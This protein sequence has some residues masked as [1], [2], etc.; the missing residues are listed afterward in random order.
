MGLFDFFKREEEVVKA[1]RLTVDDEPVVEPDTEFEDVEP[2]AKEAPEDR[3]TAGPFDASEDAP[4]VPYVDLG[5]LRIPASA[6]LG[7][8]LEMDDATKRLVAVALDLNG[9]TLQ[10]QAFAAP[11]SSGLWNDVR[12]KLVETLKTQGGVANE[13]ET[14]IGTALHAK[15]PM[16]IGGDPARDVH[17]YGVDGPRWFLRGVITGP[18]TT[19]E[20]RRNELLSLFRGV[21]VSR[22]NTPIPPRDLLELRMP[23]A[24]VQQMKAAEEKAKAEA[25]AAMSS[26]MAPQFLNKKD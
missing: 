9:S 25:A 14:E 6:G 1:E 7:L 10:V 16:M 24:M 11:R 4:E 13:V 8:R 12:S 2:D 5:S 18:A 26:Q 21:V 20:A 17:F 19:D 23:E 15:V 3:E 22:G